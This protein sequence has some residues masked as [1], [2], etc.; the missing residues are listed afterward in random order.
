MARAGA[1]FE[2]ILKHYY[3]GV[4]V[5]SLRSPVAEASTIGAPEPANA[6]F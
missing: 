4:S 2:D 5:A 1:S 6:G 3:T